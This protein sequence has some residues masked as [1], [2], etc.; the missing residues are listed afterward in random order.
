[1]HSKDMYFKNLEKEMHAI[2]KNNT[3][4]CLECA[5]YIKQG[6]KIVRTVV[7]LESSGPNAQAVPSKAAKKI[8]NKK[9]FSLDELNCRP[10]SRHN[11]EC[12]DPQF[13]ILNCK[14]V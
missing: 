10:L 2:W 9:T 4:A 14:N 7:R 11:M 1:M 5:S 12:I 8:Q 3:W 6:G 13:G